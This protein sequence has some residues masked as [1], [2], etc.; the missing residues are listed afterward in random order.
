ME[1]LSGM[2]G[3]LSEIL[4]RDLASTIWILLI[5]GLLLLA[6]WTR[7]ERMLIAGRRRPWSRLQ[8][9]PGKTF[10][11]P[12]TLYILQCLD[13]PA[14]FKIGFTRRSGDVRAREIREKTGF[15]LQVVYELRMPWACEVEERVHARLMTVGW[16]LRGRPDFGTEW[17]RPPGGLQSLVAIIAPVA[18]EVEQEARRKGSWGARQ[19]ITEHLGPTEFRGS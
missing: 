17:Y 10:R 7:I 4:S 13:H 3:T 15:R 19:R 12:S 1:R 18:R 2:T 11:R 16:R 5:V 8:P 6:A 14:I 9:L